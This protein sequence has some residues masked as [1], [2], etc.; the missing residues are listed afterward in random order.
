MALRHLPA[1]LLCIAGAATA[2]AQTPQQ[3]P[4][5]MSRGALE[6]EVARL[7]AIVSGG[8][9]LPQRP[10]GCTAVE[11]RQFDFWLGDWDVHP[12]QSPVVIAES[13]VTLH[14]QGCVLLEHW[15]P[16]RNAHGH[17]INIYDAA[18]G[19]W[20]QTWADASGTRTEYAG[21]IDAGGVMRLDNLGR[22]PAG[23]SP[24]RQ[25]MNFQR[26]DANTVRQWGETYD[27]AQKSWTTTWSFIY[28]RRGGG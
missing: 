18:E 9:V 27:E 14:D 1:A 20:R 16:F 28:R 13:T 7:R 8:A 26:I 25:R 2:A 23:A 15:R 24:A 3:E 5:T 17:S 10:P 6:K 12:G 11:H 21:S 22:N 4:R 19:R